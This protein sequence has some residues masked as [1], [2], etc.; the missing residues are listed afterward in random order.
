MFPILHADHGL[1][2]AHR[3]VIQAE[4]AGWDGSFTI[5]VVD[6]PADCP[7]LLSGLY[8]PQ[9]GEP[10]VG[11]GEV[12]Y[13]VRG[14][15]KGPSRLIDRPPRTIRRMVII[16]GPGRDEPVIYT[17]YG[18]PIAAPREPWDATLTLAEKAEAEA[19]WAQHALS[20]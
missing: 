10:P 20:R 9:A 8:G 16:A 2:P 19:F 13:E 17:A 14:N 3:A 6:L 7:D 12:V 1:G 15:R 18:G 4:L 11:E 5:R